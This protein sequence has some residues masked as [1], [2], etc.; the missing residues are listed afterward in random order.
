MAH[1]TAMAHD[2]MGLWWRHLLGVNGSQHAL[3]PFRDARSERLCFLLLPLGHP[4]Q[5]L[6]PWW[7]CCDEMYTSADYP[8]LSH[9]TSC[10]QEGVISFQYCSLRLLCQTGAC[11]GWLRDAESNDRA[12]SL[13]LGHNAGGRADVVRHGRPVFL[14]T[15][16]PCRQVRVEM[17][18]LRRG[19]CSEMLSLPAGRSPAPAEPRCWRPT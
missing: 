5:H 9:L 6:H 16:L 18:K 14:E 12:H 1:R 7:Q 17:V 11:W 15:P 10:R 4:I 13:R 2:Q 19:A 8:D 3:Q